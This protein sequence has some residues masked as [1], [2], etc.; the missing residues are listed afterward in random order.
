MKF[1][2]ALKWSTL[3]TVSING[4]QLLIS[5]VFVRLLTPKDFGIIAMVTIFTVILRLFVDSGFGSYL[6]YKQDADQIDKS[7]VFW[8][9]IIS[10]FILGCILAI[11]SNFIAIFYNEPLLKSISLLFALNIFLS[12]FNV[13]Q[14]ALLRKD[15]NYKSIFKIN[16]GSIILSSTVGIILALFNYGVWS[17][18]WREVT[19]SFFNLAIIWHVAKW[20]PSMAISYKRLKEMLKY[21]LPLLLSNIIGYATKNIDYLIIGKTLGSIDLG[22]YQKAY[23]YSTLPGNNSTE[24]ISH[25][26]F[27]TYSKQKINTQETWNSFIIISKVITFISVYTALCVYFISSAFVINI[28]GSKWIAVIDVLQSFFILALFITQHRVVGSLFYAQNATKK[29][30]YVNVI[31][32]PF[33]LFIIPISNYGINLVA[34]YVSLIILMFFLIRTYLGARLVNNNL[35]N[36]IISVKNFYFEGLIVFTVLYMLNAQLQYSILWFFSGPI[37]ILCMQIMIRLLFFRKETLN[38]VSIIKH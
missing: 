7:T 13:V 29:E 30:M 11:L 16:L 3:N 34:I 2:K 1:R 33:Y 25:L 19:L 38:I 5:L 27:A 12:G 32:L 28:M 17:L 22:Y 8:I 26:M 21:S 18:V 20:Y 23:Q 15:R 36:Y 31:M 24:I 14:I 35:I 6:I 37:I 9:N 4:I 10:S